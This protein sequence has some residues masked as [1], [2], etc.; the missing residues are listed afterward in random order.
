[1]V[2]FSVNHD[3]WDKILV[4]CFQRG[5]LNRPPSYPPGYP[6]PYPPGYPPPYPPGYPP[7]LGRP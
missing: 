1:M 3:F 7:P 6:P 4:A 2:N 5:I